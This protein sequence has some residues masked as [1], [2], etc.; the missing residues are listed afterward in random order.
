MWHLKGGSELHKRACV[1][2][3]MKQL[4]LTLCEE[5]NQI[6]KANAD[7]ANNGNEDYEVRPL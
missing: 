3:R 4:R 1:L 6:R 2:F 7:A 5:I